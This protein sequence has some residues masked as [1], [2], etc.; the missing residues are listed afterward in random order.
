METYDRLTEKW[1]PVLNEG[2]DIK[3]AH[4]RAVT[5]VVLENQEKEF[6]SQAAQNNMLTEAAPGNNTGSASNWNPV[7]SDISATDDKTSPR[8]A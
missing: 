7:R 1:A 5:A 6:A 2:A 8:S 3:D 4:R